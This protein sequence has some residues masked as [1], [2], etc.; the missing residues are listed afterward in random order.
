VRATHT[1]SLNPTIRLSPEGV[2]KPAWDC[3]DG[4]RRF[5]M[6]GFAAGMVVAEEVRKFVVRSWLN[7][8]SS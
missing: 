6:A 3:F 1:P 8:S 2:K 4:D 5:S 7:D